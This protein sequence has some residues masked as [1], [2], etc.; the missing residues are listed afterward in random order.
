MKF[1]QP[2]NVADPQYAELL[3]QKAAHQIYF[4]RKPM[5]KKSNFGK[6]L[7]QFTVTLL[8]IFFCITFPY[9]PIFN[10][11]IMITLAVWIFL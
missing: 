5:K 1:M 7:L 9:V 2:L 8:S 11:S 3:A 10:I 6:H 4:S